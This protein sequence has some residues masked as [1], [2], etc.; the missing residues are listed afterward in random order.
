M[1]AQTQRNRKIDAHS[2][3]FSGMLTGSIKFIIRLEGLFVFLISIFFYTHLGF[4]WQTFGLLIFVPDISMLFYLFSPKYGSYAY[5]IAHT[6][7]LPLILVLLSF[8]LEY[9]IPAW[10]QQ[11]TYALTLIWIAHIGFDR[12][13]GY[14]LK[15]PTAFSHTHLGFIGQKKD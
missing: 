2:P 4:S 11:Q 3:A 8:S 1:P 7:T 9:F 12:L 14:G 13:L 6:Y 15:Y 10:Q 5:N